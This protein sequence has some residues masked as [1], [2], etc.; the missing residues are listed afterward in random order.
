MD[1]ARRFLVKIPSDVFT[2]PAVTVWDAWLSR[3]NIGGG[4]PNQ[5]DYIMRSN[6]P[7]GGGQWSEDLIIEILA[8][9]AFLYHWGGELLLPFTMS[10]YKTAAEWRQ[11][12]LIDAMWK[13]DT[14]NDIG[15][16]EFKPVSARATHFHTSRQQLEAMIESKAWLC[17]A[18]VGESYIKLRLHKC[19]HPIQYY[20]GN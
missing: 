9:G 8:M 12:H 18:E 13:S 11:A 14:G 16:I 4:L 1:D 3:F 2:R 6:E 7:S 10:E 5:I 19:R 17:I 20:L 15:P